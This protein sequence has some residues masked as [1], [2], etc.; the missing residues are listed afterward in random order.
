MEG[1][2]GRVGER[3][4]V[5]GWG[6]VEVRRGSTS[7]PRT[8]NAPPPTDSVGMQD[9]ERGSWSVAGVWGQGVEG[10]GLAVCGR[11]ERTCGKFLT[12]WIERCRF[13]KPLSLPMR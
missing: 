10:A 1:R 4:G 12:C 5:G 7:G 8:R 3:G 13:F 11:D 9:E 6:G 2:E